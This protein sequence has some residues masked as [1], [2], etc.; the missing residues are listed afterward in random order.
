MSNRPS[1]THTASAARQRKT[2]GPRSVLVSGEEHFMSSTL[3]DLYDGDNQKTSAIGTPP[4]L[5]VTQGAPPADTVSAVA[6]LAQK[7]AN[8][9]D[10]RTVAYPEK[11]P[12]GLGPWPKLSQ[13]TGVHA[14]MIIVRAWLIQEMSPPR[15]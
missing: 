2:L 11:V 1:A 8:I 7:F 4:P 12:A 9:T 13:S 14:E 10:A 5:C 15:S 6:T 3:S